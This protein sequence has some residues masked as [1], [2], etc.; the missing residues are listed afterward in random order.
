MIDDG[1]FRFVCA[2]VVQS[3]NVSVERDTKSARVLDMVHC[4]G[5]AGK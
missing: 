5:R 2:E 3:G 1:L 4:D